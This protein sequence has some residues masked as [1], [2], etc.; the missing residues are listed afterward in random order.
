M[1]ARHELEEQAIRDKRWQQRTS[2]LH[3]S[4]RPR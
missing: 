4:D 1:D 3:C 2:P